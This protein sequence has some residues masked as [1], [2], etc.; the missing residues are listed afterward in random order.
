MPIIFGNV[1]PP[2]SSSAAD[3]TN[4]PFLQGK[5]GELLASELHGK[6][7]NQNYRG[8]LYYAST[9]GAGV[10]V[11]IFSNASFTGLGIWNQSAGA[12]AKNLSIVRTMVGCNGAAPTAE[13]GFGYAWLNAGFAL[14]TAA[15]F[16]ATTPITATRGSCNVGVA[17]GQGASVAQAFSAATL[18]TAATWGRFSGFSSSTGAITTQIA[19]GMFIENFDG[20]LIVPPGFA[21]LMTSAIASGGTFGLTAVWEEVPL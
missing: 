10:T 4:L 6:Y 17:A 9:A 11:S 15:P 7:Y 13:A 2:S 16:S 19:L 12:T 20:D 8:N 14:A 18:T 21:L 3:G 5:Q 1:A